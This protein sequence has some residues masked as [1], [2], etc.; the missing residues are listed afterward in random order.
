MGRETDRR[1]EEKGERVKHRKGK[2]KS[3]EE[4][5]KKKHML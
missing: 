1:G 5:E 2:V 4:K 3:E